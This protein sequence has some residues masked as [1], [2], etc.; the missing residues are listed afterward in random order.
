MRRIFFSSF[1]VFTF[2]IYLLHQKFED[3]GE[4]IIVAPKSA[5]D[6]GPS[7]S[8]ADSPPPTPPDNPNPIVPTTTPQSAGIYRDGTY[9]G[10]V[11]DA[12]YGN[13]QV[14]ATVKNGRI[15]DVQFLD[16]PHDR[17][18]S[19]FINSQAMPILKTEA[20]QAQSANV[21][22]VTGATQTSGAFIRSLQSALAKAK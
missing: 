3:S 8:P 6:L 9:T 14:Q 2:I 13:V 7:P 15:T 10:D 19:L 12:F 1:I 18:T 11:A 20:I 22:T 17:E 5:A 4:G 16:Y 21:D